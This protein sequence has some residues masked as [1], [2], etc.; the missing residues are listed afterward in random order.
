MACHD[1][2]PLI[3]FAFVPINQGAG[4][5]RERVRAQPGLKQAKRFQNATK[6]KDSQKISLARVKKTFWPAGEGDSAV[7]WEKVTGKRQQY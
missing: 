2:I 7:P 4:L 6:V 5:S 3:Y 1:D